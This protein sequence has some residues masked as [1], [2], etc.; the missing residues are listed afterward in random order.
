MLST[1][2]NMLN[3]W[4]SLLPDSSALIMAHCMAFAW[5][6]FARCPLLCL[7]ASIAY[8]RQNRVE[9]KTRVNAKFLGTVNLPKNSLYFVSANFT[10]KS[11]D[12]FVS[13]NTFWN[14][15]KMS[16]FS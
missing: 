2:F 15:I 11:P 10:L 13:A 12:T 3:L 16:P 7:V 9:T 5:R 14:G 8:N 6:H 4:R 1:Y